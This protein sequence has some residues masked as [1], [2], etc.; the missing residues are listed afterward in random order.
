MLKPAPI[1]LLTTLLVTGTPAGAASPMRER[2]AMFAT[3]YLQV[4]SSDGTTSVASVPRLYEPT[5]AFYYQTYTHRELMAEKRRAIQRWPVRRY[6]HRPG[7]MR[8]A[9]DLRQQRCMAR[10]I[11]DFRVENT[12]Q[13]TAKQGSAKFDLGIT[14][15]GQEPRIFYEG[16]SLNSRRARSRS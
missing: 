9:C 13:G 3:R 8:I 14:F 10:S 1:V 16:G 2:T 15:A 6:A 5:V 7:T 11:I 4:W 12:R